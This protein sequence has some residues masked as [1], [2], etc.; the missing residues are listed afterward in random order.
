MIRF[1]N[2]ERQQK[3]K[4]ELMKRDS[5]GV[6]VRNAQDVVSH[7]VDNT[8]Q[9]ISSSQVEHQIQQ[10]DEGSGVFQSEHASGSKFSFDYDFHDYNY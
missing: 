9:E 2:V 5:R 7:A 1:R 10:V 8:S 4:S 3:Q 6:N